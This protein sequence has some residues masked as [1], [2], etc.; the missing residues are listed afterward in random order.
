MFLIQVVWNYYLKPN[1][2]LDLFIELNPQSEIVLVGKTDLQNATT[3]NLL[4][5][6]LK[7]YSIEKV[8]YISILNNSDVELFNL[9]ELW[10]INYYS[11]TNM[12]KIYI[13]IVKRNLYT[14]KTRE[15]GNK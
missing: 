14:R 3:S 11:W 8:K 7:K 9:L 12:Y 10:E 5:K 13:F 6:V 2:N 4:E 1:N 15:N